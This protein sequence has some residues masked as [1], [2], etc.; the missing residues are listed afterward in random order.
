MSSVVDKVQKLLAL[1]KSSNA[2]EAAAAA[3]MANKL[4]DQYRLSEAD[5]EVHG[6]NEEPL[7][8][9]EGYLYESGKVTPWKMTLMSVLVKHYGLAHW[10]DATW[11]SG[12]QVS[13]F[14]LVGRKSDIAVAKYMFTW[15]TA[16]CQRISMLEAKGMGRVYVG[17]WCAGFV[18]GVASQL[19]A[20]RAEAQKDATSAAIVKVDARADQ[21]KNFLDKL[22]SDLV[23]K[24][25]YSQA[26]TDGRA[27]M[28]GH[29]RG[30]SI[31]LGQSMG[32][33]GAKLLK[34]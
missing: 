18:N 9:D 4:I 29:Q 16:E 21:S 6:Q 10:N 15:L 17:S 12:R 34:A 23:Y 31:H 32:S 28:Q 22:H 13:R 5:L 7:E 2:H 8:E 26:Q 27:F 14:K 25:K 1:S 11:A 24:K 30:Q 3:A 20:S 33:G 19:K